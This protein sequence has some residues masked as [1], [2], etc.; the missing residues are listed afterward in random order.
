MIYEATSP[1]KYIRK[2]LT[3]CCSKQSILYQC[4]NNVES[5]YYLSKLHVLIRHKVHGN[6]GGK[7]PGSS[8][9]LR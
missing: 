3:C 5:V 2:F 4:K 1:V 8:P 7:P 6:V 9:C